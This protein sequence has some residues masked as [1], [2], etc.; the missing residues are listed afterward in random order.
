MG[1]SGLR[2][3]ADVQSVLASDHSP[4]SVTMDAIACRTLDP[5]AHAVAIC[6]AAVCATGV[7]KT[8]PYVCW[9]SEIRSAP[10]SKGVCVQ[11]ESASTPVESEMSGPRPWPVMARIRRYVSVCSAAPAW[12]PMPDGF[13]SG[14]LRGDII[15]RTEE[16]AG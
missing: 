6:S 10:G 5:D 7:A 12:M 4:V 8:T 3:S 14:S 1:V 11:L 16:Y 9:S 15:A 2:V 13:M